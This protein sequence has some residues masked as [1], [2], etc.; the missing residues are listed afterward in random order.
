METAELPSL[1]RL[2]DEGVV[3]AVGRT[4]LVRLR[5]L[6]PGAEFSLFAKLEGANPGGS[7]KDRAAVGALRAA[8]RRGDVTRDTVV[9]ESSS[10]NMAIG[11]AQACGYLKIPLVCVL[12][13]RATE[14]NVAIL[15]AYGARIEIVDPASG[16]L[17]AARLRRVAELNREIENSY[18]IN[19]YANHDITVGYRET[20]H[21]AIASM[22]PIDRLFVPVGTCGLLRGCAE[23]LRDAGAH[24]EVVAVDAV[25][26]VIFGGAP[27]RRLLPGHG[28]EVRPALYSGDLAADVVHMTDVDCVRYCHRLVRTEGILA[29][30]SSGA[31]L[32][33]VDAYRD[34]IPAG[35]RCLAILSDRG[36]R[37][38]D[39]VFSPRW[40]AEELGEDVA[41]GLFPGPSHG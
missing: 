29:G 7:M 6:F 39:T 38:L 22:G 19:Q 36:E 25:G 24:T 35:A 20:L 11:L 2:C 18:W 27:G 8:I 41:A 33:A 9:L 16:G 5:Q 40:V 37:Y 10:G 4:P 32:G 14:R 30:A 23:Y 12:D 1:D 17:L 31:V 28:A 34:R 26:S 21:E 13:R 15:R 3:A